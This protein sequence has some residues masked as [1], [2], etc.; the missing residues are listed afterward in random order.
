MQSCL[1]CWWY[2]SLFSSSQV[3]GSA[4]G[5]GWDL[6]QGCHPQLL[7]RGL[8][9]TYHRV[10][11]LQRYGVPWFACYLHHFTFK[12]WDEHFFQRCILPGDMPHLHLPPHTPLIA[13]LSFHLVHE[14]FLCRMLLERAGRGGRSC[15][16][17]ISAPGRAPPWLPMLYGHDPIED[18]CKPVHM[19]IRV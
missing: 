18:P 6:R 1:N 14:V 2:F 8:S 13:H 9:C 5:P 15:M 11:I 19:K 3:C 4:T 17:M 10:E 12:G 16:S 7:S